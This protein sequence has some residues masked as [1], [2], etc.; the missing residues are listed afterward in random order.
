MAKAKKGDVLSCSEC[1]LVVVVD[2]DCGC[3]TTEIVCCE[4][5]MAKGKL[6]AGK[7][8]K[9]AVA[10]AASP[11]RNAATK[12]AAA[13]KGRKPKAPAKKAPA[14]KLP[15]KKPVAAAKKK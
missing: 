11:A 6:A 14:K 9:K 15:A 5:P 4:E 7:A 13:G 2:E 3:A 8:K 12:A 10:K 1:G